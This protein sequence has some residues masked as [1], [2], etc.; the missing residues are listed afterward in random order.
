VSQPRMP[1]GIRCNFRSRIE[2][3]VIE[4]RLT[5]AAIGR[6]RPNLSRTMQCSIPETDRDNSR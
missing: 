4:V 1:A 3:K 5:G 2:S 6:R